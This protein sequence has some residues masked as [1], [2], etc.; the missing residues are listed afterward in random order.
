[1]ARPVSNRVNFAQLRMFASEVRKRP[2]SHHSD[3]TR[4]MLGLIGAA[5]GSFAGTILWRFRGSKRYGTNSDRLQL[6]RRV[7][8]VSRMRRWPSIVPDTADRDVYLVLEDFGRLGG[9]W[10]ETD[11]ERTDRATVVQDL[12]EGQYKSPQRV[13]AFNTAEGWSR[14][15]SEDI[16]D[17]L[18]QRLAAEDDTPAELQDL[19][20]RLGSGGPVQLPLPLRRAS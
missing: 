7:I 3:T 15:V 9:C 11:E 18:L 16:A 14:D 19:I 8:G 5:R 12:F 17:E 2:V 20:D 1:M 4:A 13:V 10:R 6:S